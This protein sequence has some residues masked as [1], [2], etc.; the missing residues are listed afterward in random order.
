MQEMSKDDRLIQ[1]FTVGAH[2]WKLSVVHITQSLFH[3][4][5][6]TARINAHYFVLLKSNSDRLQIL[7]FGKQLFPGQTKYFLDAYN[8]AISLNQYGYLLVDCSPTADENSRLVTNIFPDETDG[9]QYVVTY[10]PQQ[11]PRT[12][13]A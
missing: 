3:G 1:L 13:K 8:D 2:H 7:N 12:R 9:Q 5:N 4:G 11:R 6:R 10:L